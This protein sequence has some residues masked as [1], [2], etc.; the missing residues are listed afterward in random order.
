MSDT[1]PAQKSK[2]SRGIRTWYRDTVRNP[3]NQRRLELFKANRRGYWSFWIFLGLFVFSFF[4]EL[5]ANDRPILAS[6]KG[7]L[8]F[9]V[10]VDY[11]EEKFGGFLAQTD[12]RDTE[13]QAEIE[14]N[15]W[16]LWPPI[17]Y[18]Y[19]TINLE[20]PGPAPTKPSWLLSKEER[21]KAYPDGVN[22]RNCT[23]GN[24]NWLGTDDNSRDVL[25]RVIYGFRISAQFGLLLTIF[26]SIIG[27]AA[28]AVQGYFGGRVDLYFQRFIEL[29]TS[30]PSLYILLI[31]ASLVPSGFWVLLGIL[32]LF[33]WVSLVGVVRAEF[34]RGRNFD[35]VRAARALG[36]SDWR[37]MIKHLLP[38]AMVATVTFMPFILSGSLVTLT[39]LDFLGLGLPVGSASLGE[40]LAQGKNNLH[41]PWLVITAFITVFLMLSLLVFTG[42]AVRDA[43]DPRKT[44]K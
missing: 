28:G 18:N 31:V 41:A 38:N 22:D 34:L 13:I 4:A 27:I 33:S 3:I 35:Y 12:Y 14:G 8:L 19:R 23:I 10:I 11:P 5:I 32:M 21:C 2:T 26:S 44:F 25:A 1:P 42:E 15:G 24:W 20:P 29:W 43:L 16:M 17:S 37:I 7:E 40:L 6:Y 39:A 36:L 9:P 30:M